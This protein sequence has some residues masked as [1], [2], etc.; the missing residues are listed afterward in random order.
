MPTMR[1]AVPAVSVQPTKMIS[2]ALVMLKKTLDVIEKLEAVTSPWESD[3]GPQIESF[4]AACTE[5]QD[6]LDT[7]GNQSRAL[8]LVLRASR[9]KLN[10]EL[11]DQQSAVSGILDGVSKRIARQSL[12]AGFDMLAAVQ[13]DKK[14]KAQQKVADFRPPSGDA[15]KFKQEGLDRYRA[16]EGTIDKAKTLD[17]IAGVTL[18]RKRKPS[19]HAAVYINLR[20]TGLRLIVPAL[21]KFTAKLRAS[22]SVLQHSFSVTSRD[23]TT[24]K[25]FKAALADLRRS[26][27]CRPITN[28]ITVPST[29]YGSMEVK[30]ASDV[31]AD[32]LVRAMPAL[33]QA[34][35]AVRKALRQNPATRLVAAKVSED[36]IGSVVVPAV[37]QW[38]ERLSQGVVHTEILAATTI[39]SKL[40]AG[41]ATAVTSEFDGGGGS[42]TLTVE[43]RRVVAAVR[44]SSD[45]ILAVITALVPDMRTSHTEESRLKYVASVL[46]SGLSA[47]VVVGAATEVSFNAFI[48]KPSDSAPLLVMEWRHSATINRIATASKTL[49]VRAVVGATAFLGT[50]TTNAALCRQI[51]QAVCPDDLEF[52]DVYPRYSEEDSSTEY[53][54]TAVFRMSSVD[55]SG[56]ALNRIAE[57]MSQIIRR[58]GT[59]RQDSLSDVRSAMIDEYIERHGTMSVAKPKAHSGRVI[60]TSSNIPC[61]AFDSVRTSAK[62][63]T[64]VVDGNRRQVKRG[65]K[66]WRTVTGG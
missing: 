52:V 66:S 33:N 28:K 1:V 58:L 35:K 14:A 53:V 30:A 12:T 42:V 38:I 6:T 31:A 41:A 26:G 55:T 48:D 51:V 4:K 21:M 61:K 59:E 34:T 57:A 22:L 43:D 15:A 44:P 24:P 10:E 56:P 9:V 8:Q 17:L 18:L 11:L 13:L 16:A 23:D 40:S 2:T 47:S 63:H 37:G 29:L 49:A 62:A 46:A 50:P 19:I 54:Q 64:V 20:Q 27:Q 5:L 65:D 32:I 60:L 25:E 39:R 7:H 3:V 36:L 45:S